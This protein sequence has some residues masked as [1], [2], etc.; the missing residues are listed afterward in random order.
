M[1]FTFSTSAV[2]KPD[3]QNCNKLK[4]QALEPFLDSAPVVSFNFNTSRAN[5]DR[6]TV[7]YLGHL[8]CEG[9]NV[10]AESAN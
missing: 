3:T 9:W 6:M 7:A 5:G 8:R 2:S 10:T 1:R 4:A